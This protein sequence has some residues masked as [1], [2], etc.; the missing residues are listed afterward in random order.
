MTP[1]TYAYTFSFSNQQ[2]L[3]QSRVGCERYLSVSL[4]F[5]SLL[6]IQALRSRNDSTPPR[7]PTSM[8]FAVTCG[9]LASR[10]LSW[11]R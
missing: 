1:M 4:I 8:M 6:L 7:L 10:W 11:R 5:S 3:V 2:S 9:P